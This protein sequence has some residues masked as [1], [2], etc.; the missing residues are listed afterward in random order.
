MPSRGDA[1]LYSKKND[2]VVQSDDDNIWDDSA[3]IRL[4]EQS[5]AK[6][7]SRMRNSS[8]RKKL[9]KVGDQCMAPYQDDGRYYPVK[10]MDIDELDET[11]LVEF[12][13]YDGETDTVELSD[14]LRES[15]V[16]LDEANDNKGDETGLV[17]KMDDDQNS[18]PI[19]SQQEAK[20]Q[21]IPIINTPRPGS[22]FSGSFSMGTNVPN[23]GLMPFPVPPPPSLFAGLPMSLRAASGSQPSGEKDVMTGMLMSWYMA[24]YHTG[25]YN[26]LQE[27]REKAKPSIDEK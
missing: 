10:I 1:V 2:N 15:D 16:E 17:E 20:K 22:G 23:T 24:G 14:L 13:G 27:G 6:T 26:G 25:M 3:L 19:N 5:K 21:K 12:T 11:C 7:M 4:Y 9:W 8:D 18:L